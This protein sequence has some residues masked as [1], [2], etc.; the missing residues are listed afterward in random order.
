MIMCVLRTQRL[1]FFVNVSYATFVDEVSTL[2]CSGLIADMKWI[3]LPIFGM[4]GHH[5]LREV[6]RVRPRRQVSC[7]RRYSEFIGVRIIDELDN[8]DVGVIMTSVRPVPVWIIGRRAV[9]K[10]STVSVVNNGVTN[11]IATFDE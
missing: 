10:L 3:I 11:H 1:L 4:T 8:D 6:R 5:V 7:M 9:S 2:T